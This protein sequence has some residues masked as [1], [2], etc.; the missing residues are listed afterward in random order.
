MQGEMCQEIWRGCC[1]EFMPFDR[2]RYYLITAMV[3]PV[4]LVMRENRKFHELTDQA[5]AD[6]ESMV[7]PTSVNQ[8]G[9]VTPAQA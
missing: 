9:S 3:Q 5:E 8:R 6:A 1:C 4:R 2:F 7:D